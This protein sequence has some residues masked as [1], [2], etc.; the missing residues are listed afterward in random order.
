MMAPA[1][2]RSDAMSIQ[3]SLAAAVETWLSG[4]HNLSPGLYRDNAAHPRALAPY[5]VARAGENRVALVLGGR[6]WADE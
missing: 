2:R 4:W 5:I 6:E 3:P 1:R